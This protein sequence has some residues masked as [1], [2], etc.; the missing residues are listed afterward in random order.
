MLNKY[1]PF[2]INT[3]KYKNDLITEYADMIVKAFQG[4]LTQ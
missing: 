2:I 4:Y 3:E 1:V